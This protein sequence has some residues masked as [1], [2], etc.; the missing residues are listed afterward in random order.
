VGLE[1]CMREAGILYEI[2]IDEHECKSPLGRSRLK[3]EDT[4]KII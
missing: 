2:F 4:I 1:A 3:M